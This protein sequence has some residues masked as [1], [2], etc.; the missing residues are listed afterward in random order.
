[1]RYPDSP[2]T[3]PFP[4]DNLHLP[5]NT[6]IPWPTSLTT[7]NGIRI[8]LAVLPQYTFQTDWPTDRPTHGIGDNSVKIPAYALLSV[9]DAAKS[10]TAQANRT[11]FI[12]RQ[13]VS[14]CIGKSYHV[15][16]AWSFCSSEPVCV[17]VI[18]RLQLSLI[19]LEMPRHC[20]AV[21]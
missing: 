1:M 19:I 9:S 10:S 8:A 12:Y 18:N 3:C 15:W 17:I 14:V 7:P 20:I 13:L 2:I 5:S 11:A 16:R 21:L 6:L 4:F